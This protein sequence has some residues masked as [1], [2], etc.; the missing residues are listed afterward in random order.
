MVVEAEIRKSETRIYK[1][2]DRF[3]KRISELEL[4]NKKFKVP[5][6]NKK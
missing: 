1:I 2:L 5:E 3:R 4:K 6:R